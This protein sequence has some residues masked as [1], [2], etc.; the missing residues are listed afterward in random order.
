MLRVYRGDN[1]ASALRIID[2]GLRTPGLRILGIDSK[3]FPDSVR[4]SGRNRKGQEEPGME[5][6]Y[7]PIHLSRANREY[8]GCT[9]P[10]ATN[11]KQM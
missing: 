4:I 3:Y 11:E 1:E 7:R 6:L 5:I 2:L 9:Q 8:A 10:Q